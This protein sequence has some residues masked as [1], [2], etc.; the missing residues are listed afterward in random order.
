MHLEGPVPWLAP[1]VKGRIRSN[2]LFTGHNLRDAVNDG[3]ADFN[4]I[5]L[6]DIPR[7]F[8][9]GMI[10]LNAALITVSPPDSSGFCTLGTSADAT[11]AA[12][13]LADHIIAISNKNMPR[14][15]GDTLI[16]ESHIDFMIEN[17]FP[18]HERKFGAKTSEVEKKIGELIANELVDNGATLQMGMLFSLNSPKISFHLGH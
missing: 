1:D 17:D 2:S 4:S 5:F 10:H 7:L 14:T 9:S 16:H 18:L 15:F 3:T 13:T 8:R 12:V 11:R 6:Q